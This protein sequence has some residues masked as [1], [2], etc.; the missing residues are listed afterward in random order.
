[1]TSSSVFIWFITTRT[2]STRVTTPVISSRESSSS[3]RPSRLTTPSSTVTLTC[4]HAWILG[5]KL[6]E[7]L[8][9]SPV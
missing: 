4:A 6:R 2:P 1:M 8:L 5:E 3:T 7:E 9:N